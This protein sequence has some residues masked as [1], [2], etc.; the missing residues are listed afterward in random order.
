MGPAHDGF[1]FLKGSFAGLKGYA[2]GRL[3]ESNR[4]KLY[5]DSG[6]G[7]KAGSIEYRYRVPFNGIHVFIDKI[8]ES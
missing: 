5:I 3:T 8:G 4:G 1:K 2:V 7:P 6:W